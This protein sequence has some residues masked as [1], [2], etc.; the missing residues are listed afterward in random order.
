MNTFNLEKEPKIASGFEVPENYFENFSEKLIAKLPN[1][2][3]KVISIF[4]KRKKWIF[5]AAAILVL[6][7]SIPVLYQFSINQSIDESTLENYITNQSTISENDL[8]DLLN[9]D[10]I[11]K[12]N[13]DL[14]IDSKSIENELLKNEISEQELLN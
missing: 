12:M 7:V 4:Q 5:A 8:V 10:A 13:L 2:E 11:Q 9:E 1:K 14:Q 6:S 3:V